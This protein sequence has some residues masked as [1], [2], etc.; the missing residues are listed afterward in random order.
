MAN[1]TL[2]TDRICTQ[3]APPLQHVHVSI[4][5]VPMPSRTVYGDCCVGPA[6]TENVIKSRMSVVSTMSV[7]YTGSSTLHISYSKCLEIYSIY[8]FNW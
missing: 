1:K 6:A 5:P 8:N 7:L 4:A 3:E 2:V